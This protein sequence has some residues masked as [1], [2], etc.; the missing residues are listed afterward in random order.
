[1]ARNIKKHVF[2]ND[3]FRLW[4]RRVRVYCDVFSYVV[5]VRNTSSEKFPQEKLDRNID[6]SLSHEYTCQAEYEQRGLAFIHLARISGNASTIFPL[7]V[8]NCSIYSV[9]ELSPL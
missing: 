1:M 2:S 8:L 4:V 3:K 5:Y 6:L 7:F 9:Q